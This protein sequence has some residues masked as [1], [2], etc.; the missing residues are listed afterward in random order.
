MPSHPEISSAPKPLAP[1]SVAV[2]TGNLVFLS[3]QVGLIPHTGERAP[4][5]ITAQAT[6]VMENITAVLGDLGLDWSA[7]VKTT[8]FLTDMDHY[9]SVNEVYGQYVG[10]PAPAR[11]ANR[12]NRSCFSIREPR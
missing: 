9:G 11:S 4:D 7:V 10:D 5:D 3:G 8:I 6:Q 1:Y 2:Q 12:R